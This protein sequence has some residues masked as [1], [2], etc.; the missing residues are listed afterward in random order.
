[1]KK[2]LIDGT[3]FEQPLTGVAKAT[4]GLYQ[5]LLEI[6]G[7]LKITILHRL[8]LGGEMPTAIETLQLPSANARVWREEDLPDYARRNDCDVLHFPWNK[9]V[10]ANLPRETLTVLTLHDILPLSIPRYFRNPLRKIEYKRAVGNSLRRADLV[11]T[12]SQFS[13]QRIIAEFAPRVAPTVVYP[14]SPLPRLST[15]SPG[16]EGENFFLFCGGYDK[17]K[18]IELLLETFIELWR[19]DDFH[20]PLWLAGA[21]QEYSARLSTLLCEARKIGAIKELGYVSDEEL[22]Q[23]YRNALAL[24]YP[25]RYEGFGLPPLEAMSLGC[26]VVTF[27]QSSLPEVCGEAALYINSETNNL[28]QLILDLSR[29]ETLRQ[30]LSKIGLQQAAQ[31]SWRKSAEIFL[32][33]L[34]AQHTTKRPA[35]APDAQSS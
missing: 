30:K 3:V 26:P 32:R 34:N 10:P 14:A 19:R 5:G 29:D 13:R 11:I 9:G 22:S 4:L 35:R 6:D 2:F 28:K 27:A 23:C 18:G 24:I 12:D 15:A 7:D 21:S 8:P 16:N 17:R 31:F 20:I 25:S 1:M 33:A